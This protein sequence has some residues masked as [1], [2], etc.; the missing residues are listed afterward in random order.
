LAR[1]NKGK[2]MSPPHFPVVP[3]IFANPKAAYS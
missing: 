3:L 2:T 1:P